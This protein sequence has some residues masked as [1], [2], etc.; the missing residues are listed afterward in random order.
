[1]R[2]IFRLALTISLGLTFLLGGCAT[3]RGVVRLDLP[4]AASQ[5][6]TGPAVFI[7]TV[8]DNRQFEDH[9][10]SADIPSVG[11]GGSEKNSPDLMK[12]AVARKRNGWGKAMGDIVLPEDQNV[13]TVIRDALD[14]VMSELGY[15][16]VGNQSEVGPEGTVVDVSIDY[17]WSYVTM[18]FSALTLHSGI[19]TE[20]K[21]SSPEGGDRHSDTVQVKAE[22]TCQIASGRNW[23][24]IMQMALDKYREEAKGVLAPKGS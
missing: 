18:G 6:A 13:E 10:A 3:N 15:T 19:T 1:M 21:R 24:N 16:V 23:K 12:R 11:F 7:R 5:A 17:F 4:Q 2:T 20:I 14:Q 9:P 22:D 8:V